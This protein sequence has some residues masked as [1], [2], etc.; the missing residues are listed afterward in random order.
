MT[1]LLDILRELEPDAGWEAV[2][3]VEGVRCPRAEAY[4][5]RNRTLRTWCAIL[6]D[7]DCYTRVEA[8]H[9]NRRTALQMAL[10]GYRAGEK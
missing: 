6:V 7:P 1:S 4:L 3:C 5:Y 10:A 8:L 9:E 2:P